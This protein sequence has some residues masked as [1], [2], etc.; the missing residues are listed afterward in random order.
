MIYS[1]RHPISIARREAAMLKRTLF[2]GIVV[3]KPE[4]ARQAEIIRAWEKRET[5]STSSKSVKFGF[6]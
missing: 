2:S 6:K 3:P 4:A 1:F 5:E